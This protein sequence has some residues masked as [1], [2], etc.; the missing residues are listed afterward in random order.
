MAS[1]QG[2]VASGADYEQVAR[3]RNV[4]STPSTGG[5]GKSMEIDDKK[6]QAAKVSIC[7]VLDA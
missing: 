2:V 5:Q 7:N 3:R 4:P 1:S 6:K